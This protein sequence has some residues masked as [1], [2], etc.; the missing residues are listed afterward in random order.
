MVGGHGDV[1]MAVRKRRRRRRAQH[2]LSEHLE[3]VSWRILDEYRALGAELNV[4]AYVTAI[5]PPEIV[6]HP[7]KRSL[8]FHPSLLP[9]FRGGNA[10]QWQIIEGERESG[11]TVFELDDGVDTGPVL[12]QRGG[13][14]I[15]PWDTTGTLFFQKLYP[16]G[17]LPASTR[18]RPT[19]SAPPRSAISRPSSSMAK[20]VPEAMCSLGPGSNRRSPHR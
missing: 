2:L 8:C 15:E 12:V 18:T 6:D 4:L 19:R 10:M 14:T 11:V 17:S 1:R 9:R 7:P 5:L 13:V 3:G 20:T 16:L